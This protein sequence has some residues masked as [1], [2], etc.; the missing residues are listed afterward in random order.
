MAF[1]MMGWSAFTKETRMEGP[2]NTNKNK[3]NDNKTLRGL[4]PDPPIY[5]ESLPEPPPIKKGL[6]PDPPPTRND[7]K[8]NATN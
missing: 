7:R 8:Q 4:P 2:R 3:D 1:K 5:K 6:S